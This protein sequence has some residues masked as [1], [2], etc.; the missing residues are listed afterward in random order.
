MPEWASSPRY[1]TLQ[2]GSFNHCTRAPALDSET[3]LQ[4]RKNDL[5]IK[6]SSEICYFVRNF[7]LTSSCVSPG[8]HYIENPKIEMILIF[9]SFPLE[10]LNC[11]YLF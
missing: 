1:P 3:Q 5:Q 11:F 2:A 8:A 4:T 10:K 9:V 7:S 6:I